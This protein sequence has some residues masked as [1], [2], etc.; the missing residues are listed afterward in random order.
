MDRPENS[1]LRTE[2]QDYNHL[3]D[4][5]G[6]SCPMPLLKMKQ[7]L[8][9]ASVGEV[10]FVKASDSGSKRDFKSYIDMTNHQL[11]SE[12]VND[13]YWFWITKNE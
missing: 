9:K 13:Q 10:V 12:E 5:V 6:M 2:S 8:N 7:A 3:V 4:A 11:R 1:S